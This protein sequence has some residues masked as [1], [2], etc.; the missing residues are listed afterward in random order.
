[1]EMGKQSTFT[2]TTSFLVTKIF[3]D[4]DEEEDEEE[5]EEEFEIF[6]PFICYLKASAF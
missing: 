2:H 4:E 1:M 5:K 6:F 3:E